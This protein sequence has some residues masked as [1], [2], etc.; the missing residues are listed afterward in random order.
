MKVTV[1]IKNTK[2]ETY[3]CDVCGREH[4]VRFL[5]TTKNGAHICLLCAW[6]M[7]NAVEGGFLGDLDGEDPAMICPVTKRWVEAEGVYRV[8][9]QMAE[10]LVADK[11]LMNEYDD[12]FNVVMKMARTRLAGCT[13]PWEKVYQTVYTTAAQEKFARR[14]QFL[15]EMGEELEVVTRLL[16][17]SH[18]SFN[19]AKITVE[20]MLANNLMPAICPDCGCEWNNVIALD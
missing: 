9:D 8:H 16:N 19:E 15:D 5:I 11:Y 12:F 3:T 18:V 10:M 17:M 2:P 7:Y 13:C 6:D 20:H 4:P 14:M 1:T